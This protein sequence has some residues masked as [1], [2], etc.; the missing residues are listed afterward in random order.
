MTK[1]I[2]VIGLAVGLA[3]CGS[4]ESPAPLSDPAVVAHDPN[5]P[6]EPPPPS[7]GASNEGTP[8]QIAACAQGVAVTHGQMPPN[9]TEQEW[10]MGMLPAGPGRQEYW[11]RNAD[12]PNACACEGCDR[13]H[14]LILESAP[15]Q[16]SCHADAPES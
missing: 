2:A 16:A 7:A 14:C 1:F 10:R 4:A 5:A 13:A 8:A 9:V 15:A 3:A 6:P 12:D 11:F